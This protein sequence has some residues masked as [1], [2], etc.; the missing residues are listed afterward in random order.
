MTQPIR[1][2]K[3]WKKM[4]R[5]WDPA[6]Q[7]GANPTYNTDFAKPLKAISQLS[8][9]AH[10][11]WREKSLTEKINYARARIYTGGHEKTDRIS[12]AEPTVI[13]GC[14][15]IKSLINPVD[16][17]FRKGSAAFMCDRAKFYEPLK[18]WQV[19]AE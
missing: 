5:T 11:T 7:W 3:H 17:P 8:S 2:G 14:D 12:G 6:S 1:S 16:S 15:V 10:N 18:C 4:G 9:R 13:G 19:K